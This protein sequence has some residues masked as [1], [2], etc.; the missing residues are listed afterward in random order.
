MIGVPVN[1]EAIIDVTSIRVKV[2]RLI[3][4]L[5]DNDSLSNQGAILMSSLISVPARRCQSYDDTSAFQAPTRKQLELQD[6]FLR[7][8]LRKLKFPRPSNQGLL[9]TT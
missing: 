9:G 4:S 1:I 5:F 2:E 6:P 7:T 8:P 3:K